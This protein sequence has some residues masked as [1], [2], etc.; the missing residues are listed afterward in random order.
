MEEPTSL[1]GVEKLLDE[2]LGAD[3]SSLGVYQGCLPTLERVEMKLGLLVD[4]KFQVNLK[5]QNP[6]SIAFKDNTP[7]L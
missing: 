2:I 5:A 3:G 1:E 7:L 6:V 4:R